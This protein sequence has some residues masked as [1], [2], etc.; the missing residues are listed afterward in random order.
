MDLGLKISNV[1][2]QYNGKAALQDCS[3][4]FMSGGIYALMGPNGCGKSTL[5]RVC[6][7]LEPCEQG[8]IAYFSGETVFPHDMVL[9]RRITLVLP[10]IGVFNTTVFKNVSYGLVLRGLRKATIVQKVNA[11]LDLVGLMPKREQQALTL[12]SGEAQRLGIARAMILEPELLFLD[13]PTA[14]IDVEN[15]AIVEK[16][17]L[18]L[19]HTGRTTVILSTHDREQ[20]ERLASHVVSMH[21]GRITGST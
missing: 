15:T 17:I 2:K 19:R 3:Y 20:A 12:S 6:A 16:V 4:T 11:A 5:L 13:E 9:R 7:L 10:R 1:H 14:S 8:N 18:G 21:N